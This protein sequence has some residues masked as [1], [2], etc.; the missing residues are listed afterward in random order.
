MREGWECKV[1]LEV[2]TPEYISQALLNETV[3]MAGRLIGVG[4]FRPSFGRFQVVDFKTT[5]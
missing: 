2:L 1:Q 4:D 5:R 3:A